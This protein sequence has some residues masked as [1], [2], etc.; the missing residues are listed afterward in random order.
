MCVGNNAP[1]RKAWSRHGKDPGPKHP[2]PPGHGTQENH[3]AGTNRGPQPEKGRGEPEGVTSDSHSVDAPRVPWRQARRLHR[4]S[5]TPGQTG[6]WARRP[7]GPPPPNRG[8]AKASRARPRQATAESGPALTRASCPGAR[9]HQRTGG[10]LHRQGMVVGWGSTEMMSEVES[11]PDL[12]HRRR[13][14]STHIHNQTFPPS[15][16]QTNIHT[17]APHVDTQNGHGT[18]THTPHMHSI[19]LD[20]GTTTPRGVVSADPGAEP[21]SLWRGDRKTTPVP[22]AAEK[23]TA[24]TRPGGQPH[25]HSPR[26]Q[27]ENRDRGVRK[28]KKKKTHAS[29]HPHQM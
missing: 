20:P 25:P 12:T 3:A 16:T 7:K 17:L 10:I 29:P 1:S 24:Q 27:T 23:P 5:T 19:L 2:G 11:K 26:H 22:A 4:Q 13:R 14:T 6:P 15:C 18:H 21:P 9:N 8:P 28:K